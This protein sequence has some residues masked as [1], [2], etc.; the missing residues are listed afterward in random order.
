M[1]WSVPTIE[2]SPVSG[3]VWVGILVAEPPAPAPSPL[4]RPKSSTLAPSA[5]SMTFPEVPMHH[6]QEICSPSGE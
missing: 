3:W 4:A 5:V 1:Y 2:P 6:P